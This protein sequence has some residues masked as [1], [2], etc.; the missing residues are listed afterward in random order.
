MRDRFEEQL[1]LLYKEMVEMGAMIEIAIDG[2]VDAL[3][4]RDVQKAIEIQK[5]D[6]AIDQREKEIESLCL[7]LLMMQQPVARDLRTI[8]SALKMITDM[9]RIGD[10]AQDISEIVEM[11]GVGAAWEPQHI[12]A[13]AN[14]TRTMLKNSI[15][16][17]VRRDLALARAVMKADDEVDD[18]FLTVRRDLIEWIHENAAMGE[19]A[20]DLL[21]IAKYFERIGD[22]AVNLAEWVEF[23][24]TGVTP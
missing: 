19:M 5:S 6:D 20:F 13:M 1:R 18:L 9:E 22:H 3:M 8:S 21:M 15:D 10:H 16:A 24:V 11:M 23:S 14:A 4:R 2:A 17:F 12:P 7:K